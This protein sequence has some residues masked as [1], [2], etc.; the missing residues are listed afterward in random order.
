MT[1]GGGGGGESGWGSCFA[2][3]IGA[4]AVILIWQLI[5]N[6][7]L[8]SSFFF[9]F[10]P[11]N[12]FRS[13]EAATPNPSAPPP[14]PSFGSFNNS[15]VPASSALSPPRYI[16][17]KYGISM[18]QNFFDCPTDVSSPLDTLKVSCK[19]TLEG[20]ATPSIDINLEQKEEK[21]HPETISIILLT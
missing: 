14:P 20:N 10:L 21:R 11:N 6:T 19:H 18:V 16:L 15:T 1:G 8:K 2:Y 12:H 13:Q 7:G 3:T 4:V 17:S 9:F 5:S